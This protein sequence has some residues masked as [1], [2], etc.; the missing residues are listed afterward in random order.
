MNSVRILGALFLAAS[1]SSGQT[2][3]Y[4]N[5]ASFSTAVGDHQV[6]TFEE[7]AHW[8]DDTFLGDEYEVC[9]L[10]IEHLGGRSV[11]VID[12]LL[13]GGYG[14]NYVTEANLNS[15][16]FGISAST[17]TNGGQNTSDDFDLL[18]SGTV[19]AAGL[20]VGN[21]G[22]CAETS[23]TTVQFLDA[24]GALIA[25]EV[26]HQTHAGTIFG[27]AADSSGV[28]GGQQPV[29]FDNR[30]FYGITT[31]QTIA[32]VRVLNGAGDG[33]GIIIDDIHFNSPRTCLLLCAFEVGEPCPGL[34]EYP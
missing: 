15:Q 27:T 23:T 7:F 20:F 29:P 2:V 8:G 17:S 10:V 25:E 21:L 31:D 9:G 1:I 34:F 4:F 24:V 11:N 33:D 14:S 5:E 3:E 30:L 26:L 16:P 12:N 32:R 6:V 22:N 19:S 18:F 13:P 28:C